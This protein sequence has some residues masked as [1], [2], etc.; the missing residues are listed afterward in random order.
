MMNIK[1]D[2]EYNYDIQETNGPT[3]EE[4]NEIM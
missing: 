3:F 1:W 4:I 2:I